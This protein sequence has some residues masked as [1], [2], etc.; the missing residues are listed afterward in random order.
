M[1]DT[2]VFTTG[3]VNVSPEEAVDVKYANHVQVVTSTNE[4]IVDF[5]LLAPSVEGGQVSPVQRH[6]QR[7]VLPLNT[8]KGLVTALANVIANWEAETKMS[9]PNT[10]APDPNDK[11]KIWS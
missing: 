1:P 9:L 11:I 2:H 5:F 6:T 3:V 10:R 7:I 4:V 8:M